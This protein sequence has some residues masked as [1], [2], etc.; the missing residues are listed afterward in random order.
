METDF[1]RAFEA[2]AEAM[3]QAA[4]ERSIFIASSEAER[5]GLSEQ[6]D[7]KPSQDYIWLCT[8]HAPSMAG[9]SMTP[10][11]TKPYR[12]MLPGLIRCAD[13]AGREITE[14]LP[15]TMAAWHFAVHLLLVRLLLVSSIS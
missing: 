7:G 4:K 13:L 3:M 8:S 5:H 1:E 10:L 2:I 6:G 14:T 11:W 12:Q 9:L 15:I